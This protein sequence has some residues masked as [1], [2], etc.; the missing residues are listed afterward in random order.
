[1]IKV[2]QREGMW[3]VAVIP[4]DH[5]GKEVVPEA[6]RVLEAVAPLCKSPVH[7]DLFLWGA[8]H[9]METGSVM[10]PDGL[11]RLREYDAVLLGAIG[12][13]ARVADAVMSWGLVQRVRKG[14]DLW[15][16]VRPA[17]LRPGMISP[18]RDVKSFDI[19]VIRENTE[20]EYSGA[21][22]RLHQGYPHEIAV[23]TSIFT[24]SAVER[25]VRYA[26]DLAR[27]RPRK[28]LTSVTKSNALKHVMVL[29]DEV[30]DDLA[31]SYPDV[32]V[33]KAHIDA[34]VMHMIN[35]PHDFDVIV[36]S[37]LFGDIISDQAAAI[38]GSIGLAAGANLCPD[39]T[40]PGMFEPIHGSAPDIAGKNIANPLAT[41]LAVAL[42][43]QDLGETAASNAIELAVDEVL[44]EGEV[45]TPDLGG[46]SSTRAMGGRLV[47]AVER[48][49]PR[50]DA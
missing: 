12:D 25:V 1:M 14:F 10:T 3:R 21:G 36:A 32:K 13:A 42:M 2:P 5:V 30:V 40:V 26:F 20:G 41:V 29:W 24:K 27:S 44:R 33:G 9:Y 6:L 49:L 8:D 23:Q 34:M 31:Q 50:T 38:Q 4:G 28:M 19:V 39:G 17:R 11:E 22:G 37:N 45:R 15:V 43:L 18:I 47:E 46:N 7:T 16:N 35:K 48:R